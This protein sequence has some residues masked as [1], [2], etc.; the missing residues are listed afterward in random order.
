LADLAARVRG[1]QNRGTPDA[2]VPKGV[3]D[4][5]AAHARHC[6]INDEAFA[7]RQMRIIQ[8]FAPIGRE[9]DVALRRPLTMPAAMAPDCA[10]SARSPAIAMRVA[11]VA[12]SFAAGTITPRQFGPINLK[13]WARAA[14]SA[15]SASEPGH[16]RAQP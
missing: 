5:E 14:C 6:L 12:L 4:I 7:S 9:A 1:Y 11:K 13:P 3:H 16:D 8:Q 10:T 15:P 2:T